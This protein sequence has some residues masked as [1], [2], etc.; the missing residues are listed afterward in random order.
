MQNGIFAPPSGGFTGAT[1]HRDGQPGPVPA[2]KAG[3]PLRALTAGGGWQ[4][5]LPDFTGAGGRQLT[6]RA[7]E[8][9]VDYTIPSGN[10]AR[11]ITTDALAPGNLV[12]ASRLSDTVEK[13]RGRDGSGT[14]ME[15]IG[16]YSGRGC[17]Y[18][19]AAD[20]FIFVISSGA[21]LYTVVGTPTYAGDS[22][23]SMSFGPVS[24]AFVSDYINA[25]GLYYCTL[26]FAPS[27]N[28]LFVTYM[29]ASGGGKV[30]RLT[31]ASGTVTFQSSFQFYSGAGF[32]GAHASWHPGETKLYVAYNTSSVLNLIVLDN[33]ASMQVGS[34]QT[35][36]TSNVGSFGVAHSPATGLM[37]LIYKWSGDGNNYVYGRYFSVTAGVNMST[38][39]QVGSSA[40]TI[41]PP[42][43]HP[44][45][46]FLAV[47]E[48]GQGVRDIQLT[49]SSMGQGSLASSFSLTSDSQLLT[50]GDV[51]MAL[52]GG[53]SG[54]WETTSSTYS[55]YASASLNGSTFAAG[56]D[57][58]TWAAL[59]PRIRCVVTTEL[60]GGVLYWRRVLFPWQNH[61]RFVGVSLT[62]TPA[63]GTATVA[64]YGAVAGG[65][66]GLTRGDFYYV[67]ASGSLSTGLGTDKVPVGLALTPTTLV[68]SGGNRQ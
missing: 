9:G 45:G 44:T 53:T 18:V 68:L 40:G 33:T 47:V 58:G 38:R 7:D 51:H 66:S 6:V 5:L 50:D 11:M 60:S 42:V 24:A 39:Y 49:S 2:P 41:S 13:L 34:T 10:P 31:Y 28:T 54:I 29:T 67:N 65:Q 37:Y 20:R 48:S 17:I 3:D 55:F 30:A 35:V 61:R 63:N 19:E 16:A 8:A 25:G 46:S 22:I 12:C 1:R 36:E 27:S 52:A 43:A 15:A 32:N 59:V 57:T 64:L 26:A 62:S 23:A 56:G 4:R 21:N 14:R